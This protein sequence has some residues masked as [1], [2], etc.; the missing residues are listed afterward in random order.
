M[1][2][3]KMNNFKRCIIVKDVASAK[4]LTTRVITQLQKDQISHQTAKSIISACK[5]FSSLVQVYELEKT[6]ERLKN[7]IKELE[8]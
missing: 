3:K 1:S 6:V 5:E 8:K 4:R 2:K 7:Q